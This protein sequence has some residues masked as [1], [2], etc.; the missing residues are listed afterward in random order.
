MDGRSVRRHCLLHR[1]RFVGRVQAASV[2]TQKMGDVIEFKLR[3]PRGADA[4]RALGYDSA[5]VR[6]SPVGDAIVNDV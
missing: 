5:V 2:E 6:P 1:E 4:S 3:M